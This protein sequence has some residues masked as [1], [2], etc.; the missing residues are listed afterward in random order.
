[1]GAADSFDIEVIHALPDRAVVKTYRVTPPATVGDALTLAAADPDFRG[2]DLNGAVVGI[3]GRVVARNR[4]LQDGDRIEIYRPLA[5]DP[6][7]ARRLRVKRARAR[8]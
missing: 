8:Q 5:I 7:E 1:V 3:F 4:A 6:K 2:V